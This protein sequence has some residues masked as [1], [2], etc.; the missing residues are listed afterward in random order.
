MI[1]RRVLRTKALQTLYA[2]FQAEDRSIAKAEKE[3]LHSINKSYELFHL[4]ML[5]PIELVKYANNK[6]ETA[7]QRLAP[8]YE[9]LHP[10]MRFV[11]NRAIAAFSQSEIF[12]DQVRSLGV[13][14]SNSPEVVKNLYAGLLEWDEFKAYME[15]D[16]N[17]FDADKQFLIKFFD[18]FL[19]NEETLYLNLEEQSIYWNDEIE[20]LI[21]ITIKTIKDLKSG[22]PAEIPTLFRNEDDRDFAL[23]L[24]R[25]AIA[26]HTD[27]FKLIEKLANNWDVER[28]AYLDMLIMSLAITEFI[29]FPSVPVKVSLNEYIELAKS[30]STAR[31]GLFVNGI[32]DKAIEQLRTD[33]VI[34]KSGRGL[35]DETVKKK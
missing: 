4:L 21:S 8:S 35:I 34:K 23:R 19:K 18:R 28:I 20:F 5:I 15:A 17:S 30:Y 32:L 9:D 29:E 27:H 12:H 14:W 13:S 10:N 25:K 33:G 7:L 22:S 3:M 6:I 31:S 11:N 2:H 1:S 26:N 24:L 16:D